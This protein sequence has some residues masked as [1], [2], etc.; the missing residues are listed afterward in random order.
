MDKHHS[1]VFI[2]HIHANK[3]AV[4]KKRR[5]K[6][7]FKNQ[8]IEPGCVWVI[9]PW[10]IIRKVEFNR[11]KR[12]VSKVGKCSVETTP[13]GLLVH[14]LHQCLIFANRYLFNYQ[15]LQVQ[16]VCQCL[17]GFEWYLW[18][19]LFQSI[20]CVAA[21]FSIREPETISIKEWQGSIN[22]WLEPA[23][24]L[25]KTGGYQ[26]QERILFIFYIHYDHV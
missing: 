15:C 5:N 4:Y 16:I 18:K 23:S 22:G 9:C 8:N 11:I 25:Q 1:V 14:M 19:P 20:I 2:K 13:R 21:W 3:Y 6:N 17:H 26:L 7:E 24:L 10:K 12:N